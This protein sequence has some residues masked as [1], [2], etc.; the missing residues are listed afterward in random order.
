SREGT[1]AAL[2]IISSA[3]SL[4]VLGLLLTFDRE[5]IAGERDLEILL[6][7]TGNLGRYDELFIVLGYVNGRAQ[8]QACLAEA[9]EGVE[10]FD[11]DAVDLP[12]QRE[13]RIKEVVPPRHRLRSRPPRDQRTEI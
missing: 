10:E 8:A 5:Q 7:E 6:V 2:D 12:T 1:V 11:E 3:V 9:T 13:H 4:L